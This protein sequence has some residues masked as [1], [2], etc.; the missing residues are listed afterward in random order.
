[1]L[2]RFAHVQSVTF[3]AHAVV[4]TVILRR[5]RGSAT[6]GPGRPR[7]THATSVEGAVGTAGPG[8][9]SSRRAEP[10]ARGADGERAGGPDGTQNTSDAAT[11]SVPEGGGRAWPPTTHPRH[12]CGGCRRDRRGVWRVPAG[13]QGSVEGAGGTAGPGRASSRRAELQARG[14]DGERAGGPDGT[15]N[16]GDAA[17]TSVSEGGGRAWPL[18]THPRHQ[19]GGCRRAKVHSR[20]PEGGGRTWPIMTHPRNQCGGCRRARR[21]WPGFE[22]T[23]RAIGSRRGRRAGGRAR[24]HPEHR[25][26]SQQESR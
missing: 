22:P 16:I 23:R 8:R 6:F 26:R 10:Q 9:A 5:G 17:T 7:H 20:V 11:T 1:M 3:F 14:A 4:C 18:T 13:P 15:R 12:Q 21:A 25:R 2:C 24:R 19:C